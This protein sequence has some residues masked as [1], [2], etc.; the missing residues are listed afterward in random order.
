[1]GSSLNALLG[2]QTLEGNALLV[3]GNSRRAVRLLLDLQ[4]RC[5]IVEHAFDENLITVL[6]RLS[7]SEPEIVC[8]EDAIVP[9][10]MG[11]LSCSRTG[12]LYVVERISGTHEPGVPAIDQKPLSR[13]ISSA[14]GPFSSEQH[15]RI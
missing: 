2:I 10:P 6:R 13:R 15:R 11:S 9:S 4:Q 8:L 5:F 3:D 7:S 14:S 1:M 12:R